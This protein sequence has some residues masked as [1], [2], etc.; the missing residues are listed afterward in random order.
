[1]EKVLE[2]WLRGTL[3]NIAPVQRAVLH[4]LELAKEDIQRWCGDLTDEQ[5]NARPGGLAP[6]AFHIRHIARSSDRL[7]T[8][9]EGGSLTPEQITVMKAELEPGATRREVFAELDAAL[10]R[11]A[12]R[13]K[14]FSV[15]SLSTPRGVGHQQMPT[16]IA[17]LLVHVADHAQRHVGQAIVT[18]K[19]AKASSS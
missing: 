11:S 10:E 16:T 8:Y 13:V 17:G 6:V 19:I 12:A 1:M 15:E 5:V 7:L 18:A 9:A 14:A 2:P 4:A 3:T